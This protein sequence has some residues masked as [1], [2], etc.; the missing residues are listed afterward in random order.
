MRAFQHIVPYTSA[1][2]MYITYLLGGGLDDRADRLAACQ[3]SAC[4][5]GA[6]CS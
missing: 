2:G 4:L 5:A 1:I 6:S 3:L